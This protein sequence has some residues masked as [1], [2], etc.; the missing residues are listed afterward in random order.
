[1]A[2]DR[3]TVALQD[4]LDSA[5]SALEDDGREAP[6]RQYRSHGL[7]ADDCDQIVSWAS[8]I[9]F[10]SMEG[11][12]PLPGSCQTVPVATLHARLT[13]C[14]AGIPNL[15]EPTPGTDDLDFAADQLARDGWALA[16]G[17]SDRVLDGTLLPNAVSSCEQFRSVDLVPHGPEG[18]MAGWQITVQVALS[19]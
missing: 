3:L 10:E 7:P 12:G 17:I 14:L 2:V 19:A 16:R 11:P 4:L 1:M 6:A 13:R 15:A 18:D 8:V 9:D 5:V